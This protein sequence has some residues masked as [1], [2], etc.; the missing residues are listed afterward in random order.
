MLGVSAAAAAMRQPS[1]RIMLFVSLL[2]IGAQR[3]YIAAVLCYV[4]TAASC[5]G[6]RCVL[7]LSTRVS[8]GIN[9]KL[10]LPSLVINQLP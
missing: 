4:C 10:L 5:A 9:T 7:L 3:S 2:L 1:L 8:T 6:L